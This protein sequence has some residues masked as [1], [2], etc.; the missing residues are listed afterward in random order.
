MRTRPLALLSLLA[1]SATAACVAPGDEEADSAEAQVTELKAY[2]ADAKRLDLGDLTRVAV[3][4]ATDGLN[5]RLA[6]PSFGAR[7]DPPQVFAAQPEP[8]RVLPNSAEIK[9]LDGV[10]SGLAARFGEQ[11][12]GTQVNAARLRHLQSGAAKYYVE[13]AFSARAGLGEAWSF[14]ASGLPSDANVTLGFDAG[15]ELVSRVILATPD[16]KLDS[17]VAAPLA[18]AKEMRGFVYPRSLDD[19]RR[20]KPGEMF[21]LRGVGKLG[22]NFGLGAPILVAEPTGGLAYR[23]LV[24]AGVSGVVGGQL[25]VQLVRL[26]GDEV[27]VDVG[28]ENGR[29]ISFQAAVRDGWGVKGICE[30]GERC[31]RTVEL[32]GQRVDLSRLIEKAIEKRLSSYLSLR[33][34]G[35][36]SN[37]SSRVSLSRFRFH[38]DAENQDEVERAL[39]QALKFDVR[40][41]Q[42]LYNRDLGE[43]E[44][45]VIADFDAVR[46]A[47]TS[48]RSFGFE[49]LG[50]NVYH[51]AVVKKEGSFIVQTPEG[52]KSILFD[53]LQKDGGWFETK[54]AFT[55]TGVGADSIDSSG[56]LKSE[57]NLFIQTKNS[58]S[59]MD[60]DFAIDNVDALLLGVAGK[61]LVDTLDIYGNKL[62]QTLW[63]KCPAEEERSGNGGSGHKVWHEACNVKLL[64]D[65]S[66]K[67]I[68][69]DGLRAIESKMGGLSEEYKNLVRTAADVRLTLQST[70]IH[71]YDALNGC[72]VAFTTDVRFDDS[73]LATLTSK[74][75][76]EYQKA[77]RN[78]LGSINQ[79]RMIAKSAADKDA[80]ADKVARKS[81]GAVEDMANV[82]AANAQAYNAIAAQE[83]GLP[84]LLG[85]KR[86]VS[87]PVAIRFSVDNNEAKMLESAQ[88]RSTSTDRALAAAKLFDDLRDAADD[89]DGIDLD[90]E[91]AALYPLIALVPSKDLDVA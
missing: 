37:A 29:G 76:D 62:Q 42:A 83:K 25:D 39:Q 75:K 67:Q 31:L 10:V 90:N 69:T 79:D 86:F 71:N 53:Q 16:D 47:T 23:I 40:L 87:H 44:P 72:N 50:M 57:A 34:E 65:P 21:A 56:T 49:L 74:S 46:A 54:H 27:V 14:A 66:F 20:M 61:D 85:S 30:D 43:R 6:S 60:D 88:L 9:A 64:D 13:S 48:T 68:K 82:F 89:L 59:H 32:A 17:L 70:G 80:A 15:A 28:V 77:L 1:L 78:Y 8:S 63:A 41:A 45:A 5:D 35:Q 3:G 52:A 18:A 51:R 38:L 11:E 12:L 55:R 22:A 33:A 26:E 73:A 7:F 58:D 2:W 19:V 4:F 81:D 91:Q 84:Q 24:S 36:A